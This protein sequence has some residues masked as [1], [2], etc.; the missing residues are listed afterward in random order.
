MLHL[1][2]LWAVVAVVVHGWSLAGNTE[3]SMRDSCPVAQIM[4]STRTD[5]G[6]LESSVDG[7]KPKIRV[8][9]P[10]R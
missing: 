8:R 3:V 4:A 1:H 10:R 2:D 6:K 5:G 9:P 7:V